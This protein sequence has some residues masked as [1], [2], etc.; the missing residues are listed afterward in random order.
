[1]RIITFNYAANFCAPDLRN[2]SRVIHM[3]MFSLVCTQ[4]TRVLLICILHTLYRTSMYYATYRYILC[5]SYII[6]THFSA[7]Q[8]EL[9]SVIQHIRS[10]PRVLCLK[11]IVNN[12]N[13]FNRSIKIIYAI[14]FNA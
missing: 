11:A 2:C 13:M 9:V 3:H 7:N 5:Y 12:L 4:N 10:S 14:L 6:H 1:M 8:S